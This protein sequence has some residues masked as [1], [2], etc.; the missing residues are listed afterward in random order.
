MKSCTEELATLIDSGEFETF[1]LYTVITSSGPVLRYTEADFD[2]SFGGH[3]FSSKT[4]RIID[5]N[6]TNTGHQKLG[7]SVD[8]WQVELAPRLT[9]PV[10]GDSYP[11]LIGSTPFLQ[12][13]NLGAFDDAVLSVDQAYFPEIPSY[14]MPLVVPATG[15]I[16]VFS[17][18]VGDVDLGTTS[19]VLTADSMDVYLQ[20]QLPRNLFQTS[21]INNVFDPACTLLSS[22]FSRDSIILVGSTSSVLLS[23]VAGAPGFG[24]YTLG[25][26]Q[27]TSGANQGF[28][29]GVKIW[30]SG[31]FTLI[32]P[33]PYTPQAG[34]TFTAYA[35][36]DK[37]MATCASV[38]NQAN[39]GG[40]PYIPDP[41]TAI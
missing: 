6:N 33:L 20:R 28:S 30:V 41:T 7:I 2:I 26:I 16:N 39:Y 1:D 12:A 22:L 3:V 38:G 13:A 21:C 35:G 4:V 25:R 27:M 18:P 40:E 5:T 36:C 8:N 24:T 14:P 29:R 15:I 11:D 17:G 23:S 32:R 37:Q 19:V 10:T 9:E 31:T 34:D